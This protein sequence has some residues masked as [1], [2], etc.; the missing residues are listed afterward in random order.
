MR[1]SVELILLFSDNV[2]LTEEVGLKVRAEELGL[3]VMGPGAGTA[4][5]G[6]I[7]LGFANV[8]RAGA[9]GV[10]AA[11][12]TGAQEVM[13]L[14][15]RWG[16]GVTHVIGV[17]GRDLSD[18]VG[19]RMVRQALR[20]LE[21]DPG[22]RVLLIVSKPPSPAVAAAT[23]SDLGAKPTV[24]ALVGMEGGLA[25]PEGVRLA[26]TLEE[27]VLLTQIGRAHV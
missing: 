20:A 1:S 6:G 7:G 12:G 9:V 26:R 16:A 27:A 2:P 21:D 18:E 22:T 13:S 4:V 23:L 8:V 10:V 15:D 24:A 17:G 19:G 14:L 3:L 5:I 25:V 11:A